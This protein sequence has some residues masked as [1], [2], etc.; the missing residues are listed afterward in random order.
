LSLYDHQMSPI[1]NQSQTSL[2][3][4]TGAGLCGS[5]A[6]R[7]PNGQ[8]A[9]CGLG[10]RQPLLVVSPFARS[11]AVDHSLT[12]Q[13]SVVRFIEDNWKLGRIEGGSVDARAGSL[14]GL[15]DFNRPHSD[16][17]ILDPT[18]GVRVAGRQGN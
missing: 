11:N 15:F 6:A 4:L 2:D 16:R 13:S 17:L 18:T 10:P 3:A 5:N 9:R 12:D 7:V 14:S 1:L 8:Q